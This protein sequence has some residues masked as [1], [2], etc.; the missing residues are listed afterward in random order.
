MGSHSYLMNL[1]TKTMGTVNQNGNSI[2]KSSS[3][4]RLNFANLNL[5]AGSNTNFELSSGGYIHIGHL[6]MDPSANAHVDFT[7]N[8]AYFL[9]DA[10]DDPK[11][12]LT[13]SINGHNDFVNIK[14]K[15]L[16]I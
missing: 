11:H 5:G 1:D 4:H 13:L 14:P 9:V 6:K 16:L 3:A 8:Y 7:G 2:F 10:I 15:Q 12:H